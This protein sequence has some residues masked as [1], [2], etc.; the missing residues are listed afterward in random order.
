MQREP[1]SERRPFMS[2]A[3][4]SEIHRYPLAPESAE[5]PLWTTREWRRSVADH[6]AASPWLCRAS[7]IKTRRGSGQ[8]AH[9]V[10]E[11]VYILQTKTLTL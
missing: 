3:G 4:V 8:A 7:E 11:P 5:E 2:T 1:D 10:D 6:L 9:A